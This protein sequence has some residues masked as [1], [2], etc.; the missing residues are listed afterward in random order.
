MSRSGNLIIRNGRKYY[1]VQWI[2][3]KLKLQKRKGGSSP[4]GTVIR[5][6]LAAHEDDMNIFKKGGS[7]HISPNVIDTVVSDVKKLLGL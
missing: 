1:T 4:E 2:Q 7:W 3:D 5:K 6:Y